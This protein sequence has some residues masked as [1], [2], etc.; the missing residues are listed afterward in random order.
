MPVDV[1]F[2]IVSVP[3]AIICIGISSMKY[4]KEI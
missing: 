3:I 1:W 2:M 4:K